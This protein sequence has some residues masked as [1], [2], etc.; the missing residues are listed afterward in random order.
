MRLNIFGD[1]ILKGVKFTNNK[2]SL[3]SDHDFKSFSAQGINVFNFSKMG[4]TVLK[5]YQR[6]FGHKE[7]IL[8]KDAI[9]FEFGGNDCDY[10]WKDVSDEP[11]KNHVP[12]ISESEFLN[13]YKEMVSEAKEKCKAVYITN[14]VPL[15]A[16]RYMQYISEGKNYKNIL[17]WLGDISMLYRW[18]EHY[19]TLAEEVARQTKAKLIDIRTPFLLSHNYKE[20]LS[21]DGI[22]PTE[23]GHILIRNTI[24]RELQ[25]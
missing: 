25:I 11:F 21:E 19:S 5:G 4:S 22:H 12:K 7:N 2:Y 6:F 18:Q 16:E 24:K 14:L 10:N 13:Q 1:S 3:C 20:L 15:C 23:Q 8:E 9:I 17:N